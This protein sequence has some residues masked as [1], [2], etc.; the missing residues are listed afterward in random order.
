MKNWILCLALG[1]LVG[2]T[3]SQ[4]V[5]RQPPMPSLTIDEYSIG[6]GDQLSIDVWKSPE[7]SVSV[8]VRPDGKVSVPLI[9]DVVAAG[10]TTTALSNSL[11]ERFSKYLRNA[12]VTVI[13]VNPASGEYLRRVSVTGAVNA[14]LSVVHRQGMTVLNLVLEAGG[15]TEFAIGNR[16]QLYRKID[17]KV[18]VYPVNLDDILNKG[19]LETNYQLAPS[20]II[21]V[22]ER[23]F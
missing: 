6:I 15:L 7:L 9:G 17:G 4:K 16:A 11:S 8:P 10:E 20:D 12:Q 19:K 13:V 2:C 18:K 23:T 1:L 22:P 3:G 14:P 5:V 21:T